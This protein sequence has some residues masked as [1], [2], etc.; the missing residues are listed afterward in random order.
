MNHGA[1]ILPFAADTGRILLGERA[2]PCADPYTWAGFGGARERSDR[3]LL[4]TALREF[5]EE[6]GYAG[7]M[8]IVGHWEGRRGDTLARV[9]VGIVPVEFEPRLNWEHSMALWLEPTHL[10]PA[11]LHWTALGCLRDY[12]LAGAS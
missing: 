6:V 12:L 5:V 9:F 4:D 8:R 1:G 10:D 2:Y 7:P 3:T 11:K